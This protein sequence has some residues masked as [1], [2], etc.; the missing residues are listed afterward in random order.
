MREWCDV[1]LSRGWRK[2]SG[3]SL[4]LNVDLWRRVF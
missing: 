2:S 1:W 4:I 3:G